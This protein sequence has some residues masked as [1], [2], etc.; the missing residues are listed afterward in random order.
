[1]YPCI[2]KFLLNAILVVS[3]A[4]LASKRTQVQFNLRFELYSLKYLF[5]CN[6][7]DTLETVYKVTGY[8]VNP[9]LS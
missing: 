4:V 5:I 7:A 8:E 1:M 3:E 9:D 6:N 2:C